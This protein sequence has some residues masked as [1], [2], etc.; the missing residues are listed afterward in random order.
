MWLARAAV[1]DM[2]VLRSFKL[3]AIDRW[4]AAHRHIVDRQW[5]AIMK[6]AIAKEMEDEIEIPGFMKVND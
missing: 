2:A 1:R 5:K 6:V 3:A 4:V